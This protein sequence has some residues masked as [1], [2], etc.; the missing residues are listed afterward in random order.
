MLARRG[1]GTPD[2]F[3][4]ILTARDTLCP[5]CARHRTGTG[6]SLA[7]SSWSRPACAQAEHKSCRTARQTGHNSNVNY[8][9]STGCSATE[10][11][12]RG[13]ERFRERSSW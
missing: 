2:C 13:D 3:V 8:P 6:T 5:F 11:G 7:T 9:P 4:L 10:Q 12:G 1:P